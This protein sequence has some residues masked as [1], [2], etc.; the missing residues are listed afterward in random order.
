MINLTYRNTNKAIAHTMAKKIHKIACR[1]AASIMKEADEEILSI[2]EKENVNP[3][4]EEDLRALEKQILKD[5]KELGMCNN[6]TIT[7][8]DGFMKIK[9]HNCSLYDRRKSLVGLGMSPFSCPFTYICIELVKRSLGRG[10]Q[11]KSIEALEEDAFLITLSL[12]NDQI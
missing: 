10:A 9:I 6:L 7:K 11:I 5:F 12:H 1:C 8:L 2:L 4:Q 3:V